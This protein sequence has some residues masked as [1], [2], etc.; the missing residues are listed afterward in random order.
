MTRLGGGYGRRSYAHWLIEAALIS[1]R[2]KAP[3]KLIYTRKDDMT[4]GIYRPTYSAKY[5]A[6]LDADNKL[7]AFHVKAGG[8]LESPLYA[9]RFPA[10]AVDHCL[11][12]DWSV[13]HRGVSAYFCH[14]SYVAHVLDVFTTSLLCRIYRLLTG[15]CDKVCT[16]IQYKLVFKEMGMFCFY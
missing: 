16:L 15:S 2:M 5:R 1:Q 9:N 6:A 3:I 4:A 8:I 11:A 10:G 14:D 12:E 7:N 13:V